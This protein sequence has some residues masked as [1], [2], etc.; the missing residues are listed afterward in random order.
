MRLFETAQKAIKNN[1]MEISDIIRVTQFLN[2][3]T[4]LIQPLVN[5]NKYASDEEYEKYFIF[6]M[7]WAVGG[8]LE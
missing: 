4:G 1:V 5:Q 7:V 8:L 2:L 3:L 6:S